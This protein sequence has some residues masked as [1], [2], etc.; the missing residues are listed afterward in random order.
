MIGAVPGRGLDRRALVA[1]H[2]VEVTGVEPA[3][4]LS[5]GNGEFCYTVDLTGLQTFPERYPVADHTGAGAG[6]L[7]GTQSQWGWHSTPGGERYDL[8]Q[9]RRDYDTPRGPVPYVD[10][11]GELS[12]TSEA[13]GSGAESWLRN[14]PHRLDLGRIGLVL[15]AGTAP[16]PPAPDEIGEPH[17]RLDLWTGVIESR[18]RLRGEP[19][20]VTTVCHP[21]RDAVAVRIESALL[22]SAGLAVRIAFPY[23]SEGWSNPADWSRPGAH[24]SVL[25]PAGPGYTV[26]R[27][28]D[29]TTYGVGLRATPDAEVT[30]TGP[31][32]FV[33]T[34]GG[35][36]LELVVGFAPGPVRA[37]APAVLG[38]PSYPATRAASERHWAEFWTGGGAVELADSHD[39]RAPELERRIVL[40][41]FLTA[42]HCAGSLP[43][44]ETGLMVN[45][46][47]G[48]FHLEM[49]WWHGAHF[50]LWGRPALLERSLGWYASILPRARE[51]ARE[52]GYE[53]ARWPKQVGPDGRESPSTIGTFLIW[54]QPHPIF[55]AELVRR[56]TGAADVLERYADVVLQSA[57][58]MADFAV[59]T[60][61]GYQLGPPLVP[62]QESYAGQRATLTNPTFELAYWAW[63]LGV[64]Q[65]WRELLGLAP[66]PLWAAVA[67]NLVRPHV[68]DGVYTA[69]DTPPY[70]V[71]EDHPSMLYALGVVPPT[72]LV[73]PEI[74]RATLR[75]V[76]AEWNWESTW[77]WDYPAMAMTATRLG[78]PE[79]ALDLLLLD[80]PKNIHLR[81]GHNRQTANLPIY[82]PGNGGLLA[83]TALMV[84]GADSGPAGA[85]GSPG[86]SG[87]SG[88]TGTRG[89]SGTRGAP[90]FPADGS[91]TVRHEGL[92]PMP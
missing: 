91:W 41:Q 70:T 78:E 83:A 55:L 28:L 7:L 34:S 74:M 6:T 60:D 57:T 11:L 81:N 38:P 9:T 66:E 92:H 22:T 4:P 29:D 23:G 85:P 39:P 48:R 51:T 33:V 43:P 63:A 26:E 36:L 82:L 25:A 80:T 87:P 84:A 17:Q 46:W 24:S 67:E 40:S 62:A 71:P 77:G 30:R 5:V 8:A 13:P 79:L 47:R 18:F 19:V 45:S 37:G 68:R 27:V 88:D 35:P 56:A 90:G 53:G 20:R 3:S 16:R 44:Q 2:A 89:G 65:R 59:R 75:R 12:A 32:E 69:I 15:D 64:A 14:N 49:S 31:H 58:F 21:E 54:Q 10:M 1:R 61:R 42:I 52:Q 86:G 72:G 73:D 50:P 76:L